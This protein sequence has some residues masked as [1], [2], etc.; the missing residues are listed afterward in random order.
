V[1]EPAEVPVPDNLIP[2]TKPRVFKIGGEWVWMCV[3]SI[4]VASKIA[5]G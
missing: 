3:H 1:N 5:K 2:S 4:G